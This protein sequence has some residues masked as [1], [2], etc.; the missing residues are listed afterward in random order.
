[1]QTFTGLDY[2]YI[3]LANCYGLDKLTWQDRIK[4]ARNM[5]EN[6]DVE[7]FVDKA[8]EP[9]MFRKTWK[10]IED[11]WRGKP[12]ACMVPLDATASGLQILA[13]L[14]G[15]HDTAR[16]V[17]LINTGEREDVYQKVAEKMTSIIGDT[18]TKDEV[19]RPVMTVFYGSKEQPKLL[20][21]EDTP[22]LQAFYDTLE[23]E[24][25]GALECMDDIQS[26]W[27]SDSLVHQWTL[28]DG[29]TAYIPV[30]EEKVS[31]I[32][33][34]ELNHTTF[35]HYHYVNQSSDYGI[36]LAANVVHS[37]DGYIVREM[38]RR[39]HKQGFQLATIHDSFWA[40]PN[41]MNHV[42]QNYIDILCEITDSHLLANILSQ[43][44]GEKVE[45]I[46]RSTDLSK[47]IK[48]SEYALS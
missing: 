21:G 45:L 1:M 26:C 5:I 15:C 20:F 39:A 47:Y 2:L 40:H 46:K 16:N 37:I 32:E 9:M 30:M 34:D 4:T 48:E 35:T 23:E 33:V 29:H 3:S 41:Y 7:E 14:I 19:K 17:N 42:R 13:C 31:K 38:V 11:V 36:S 24:L 28:P 10:A 18:I 25:G 6:N 27:Q 8:V 44:C 22:E 12:T 43:I